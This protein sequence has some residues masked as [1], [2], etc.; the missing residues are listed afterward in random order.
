MKF[1]FLKTAQKSTFKVGDVL[2]MQQMQALYPD[3]D[4]KA[5][6]EQIAE[7]SH[8]VGL[9]LLMRDGAEVKIEN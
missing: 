7:I 2:N 4:P 3:E 6:L 5:P 9:P 1:T 8:A